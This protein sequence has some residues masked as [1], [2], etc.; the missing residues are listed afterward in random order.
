MVDFNKKLGKKPTQKTLDPVE[1]YEGLDRASD[2]GPLRPVQTAVLNNW[3]K[4][5]RDN[6]D[7]I[8][9]LHTGQGKTLIGLLMLLSKLHEGKAPAL[10]LCPNNFLVEQTRIQAKQ[11]GIYCVVA[12]PELPSEFLDGTAILI[13]SVQKLFNGRTKFRLGP[14]SVPVGTIVLDDSHACVD[15]IRTA[16]MLTIKN[17]EPAYAELVGLFDYS[18]RNQGIGTYQELK[19]GDYNAFLPVPYWDWRDRETETAQILAKYKNTNGIKFAW[20][21]IKDIIADCFC[22][23]SGTELQISPYL[24][25]LYLFGSYDLAA[26]RIFMSATVTN[27]AFLIKGLGLDPAIVTK[28]LVHTDEKWSG[29]KMVLIPSLIDGALNREEIV[30]TFS[31][32]LPKRKYGV[33]VLAPSFARCEDWKKYGAVVAATDTIEKLVTQLRDGHGDEPIVFVNRYDGIDLPDDA[34]RILIFDS[35][36]HSDMLV[37]RYSDACR[38]GSDVLATKTARIIEQGLGRSVRG[39]KDYCVILL[40]GPDLVK[41]VR[42]V[43]S[44]RFFSDQTKTQ[45]EIGLEIGTMALDDV[46]EGTPPMKVLF[47][48]IAQCLKRDEGWKSFY[49]DRMNNLV[50]GKEPPKVLDMFSAELKAERHAQHGEHDEAVKTIQN[51]IDKSIPG[52]AE[53]GWYLQ[54]MARYLYPQSKTASNDLQVQAHKANQYLLRPK[55]GMIVTKLVVSQKRIENIRI[56]ISRHQSFEELFLEVDTILNDLRFGVNA[57]PFEKAL[58]DLGMML[59][60]KTERPDKQ[61]KEGPDNLWAIRDNEYLLFECK[62]EV[63]LQRATINKQE[64]GQLNNSCAWFKNHYGDSKLK[65]V[66]VIPTK[67]LGDGAG[68]N[69]PVQIMRKSQLHS[70]TKNVRDFFQE[71]KT[72][73]LQNLS[74]T[75]IQSFI[76]AHNLSVDKILNHYYE[77]P[78]E[79]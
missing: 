49:A 9:K 30:A 42:S 31:K 75:K 24:P 71:F 38:V 18:L 68:F 53:K 15:A 45:V 25:P 51:L 48:L 8:L 28:P 1:I 47:T 58:D 14:Q 3:H 33:V 29:E 39:E 43:Q 17:T 69:E 12:E 32:A 54:E 76:N 16:C 2:K 11:F 21:L 35:L 10:Y 66:M 52:H 4:D 5:L 78:V 36:P 27:D 20:P 23:V 37:D 60:F 50:A 55:T 65:A 70:L 6:R 44:R 62:S 63:S 56:R 34:C 40:I 22:V 57:D 26:H 77:S 74:E 73:D 13:T 7:L 79:V 64:T 19:S 67:K 41:D 46:A 61:W 72:A 59:G